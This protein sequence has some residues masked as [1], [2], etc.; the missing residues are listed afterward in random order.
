M[1]TF[2]FIQDDDDDC[3]QSFLHGGSDPVFLTACQAAF[4]AVS[5]GLNVEQDRGVGVP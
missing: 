5:W 1:Q 4:R 3:L 2:R